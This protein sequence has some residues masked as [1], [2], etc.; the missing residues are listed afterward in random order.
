[1]KKALILSLTILFT[2]Q[3]DA[4]SQGAANIIKQRAKGVAG[5]KAAPKT[6]G[7]GVSGSGQRS[8]PASYPRVSRTR[9]PLQLIQSSL[10]LIRLKRTLNG[11]HFGRLSAALN[12]AATGAKP[13]PASVAQLSKSVAEAVSKHRLGSRECKRLAQAL[14]EAM[15]AEKFTGDLAKATVGEAQDSFSRTKATEAEL[16]GISASF[17]KVMSEQ[18]ATVA[19]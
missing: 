7:S 19:K 1:M 10:S 13:T 14:H 4:S 18:Q 6:G 9:T 8:A 17:Q 12:A 3:F 5:Q 15:N 11:D 16:G 2:L